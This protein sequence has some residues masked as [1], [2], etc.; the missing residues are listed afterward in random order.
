MREVN[1]FNQLLDTVSPTLTCQSQ[2]MHC[3]VTPSERNIEF[4]E[5]NM[6]YE[7]RRSNFQN[8]LSCLQTG[9]FSFEHV[10]SLTTITIVCSLLCSAFLFTPTVTLYTMLPRMDNHCTRKVSH[11][12]NPSEKFCEERISGRW[13]LVL[14]AMKQIPHNSE[15]TV[16]CGKMFLSPVSSQTS[17]RLTS[18]ALWLVGSGA[19][20]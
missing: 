11:S 19:D 18:A 4:N 7:T 1:V 3:L 9:E 20:M 10:P 14:V 12:C 6:R 17:H 8:F 2:T 5:R 13:R 15:I 16:D